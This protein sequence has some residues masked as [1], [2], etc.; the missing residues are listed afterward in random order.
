MKDNFKLC[1]LDQTCSNKKQYSWSYCSFEKYVD[2]RGF[3]EI[4]QFR[5]YQIYV[6]VYVGTKN[7]CSLVIN[8]V[9][10]QYRVFNTRASH[11]P[12]KESQ[13]PQN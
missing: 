11:K 3:Q 10:R 4:L 7:K 9:T 2:F 13:I 1:H 6:E 8:T 12:S 5:L